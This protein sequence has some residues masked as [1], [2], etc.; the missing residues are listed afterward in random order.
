M[1]S[2]IAEQRRP[3]STGPHPTA[4]KFS[5]SWYIIA[6]TGSRETDGRARTKAIPGII[7]RNRLLATEDGQGKEKDGN[8]RRRAKMVADYA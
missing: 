8:R 6:K 7:R 2:K 3:T 5:A 1:E 4:A